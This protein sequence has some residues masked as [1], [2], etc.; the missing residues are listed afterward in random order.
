MF[1][2]LLNPHF[3]RQRDFNIVITDLIRDLQQDVRGVRDDYRRDLEDLRR[4]ITRLNELVPVASR[5]N[6]ALI[7]ALDRKIESLTSRLRDVTLPS[8][9]SGGA[10]FRDDFVY[11]RMEDALRGS[12]EEIRAAL[13]PYV[14]LV[15]DRA[16][17]IDLGCG[18]GEFLNALRDAGVEARGFDS[19][20]RSVTELKAQG[21]DVEVGLIP[22]CLEPLAPSSVGAIFASHVVEHLPFD[23]LTAM[24]ASASRAL[25]SGGLLMLETPNAETL[26]MSA[27]DFWR[28]PT[29]LGPRPAAALVTIAREFGFEVER[30]EYVHPYPESNRLRLDEKQPDDLQRMVRQLNELLFGAQ[31]L[32]LVLR[33]S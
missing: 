25:R 19:N 33:K 3:N 5:R 10:S 20:E 12:P 8:L 16:P 18:R 23:V 1:E 22:Q 7:A 2:G 31:D 11:R 27:R 4:E 17:V 32:R 15:G 29:H 28:D 13:Q 24:F 6:D 21:L 9:Q 14:E 30:L 26:A